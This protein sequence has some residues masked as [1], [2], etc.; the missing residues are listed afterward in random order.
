MSSERS[1]LF[2]KL[3]CLNYNENRTDPARD[4]VP[5]EKLDAVPDFHEEHIEEYITLDFIF[6]FWLLFCL[7]QIERQRRTVGIQ[8]SHGSEWQALRLDAFQQVHTPD[9]LLLDS[10]QPGIV[11]W[12]C[13]LE[14]SEVQGEYVFLR[15][16]TFFLTIAHRSRKEANARF[17][18]VQA[19]WRRVMKR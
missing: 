12:D 3:I 19:A 6:L 7:R 18:R 8:E 15:G 2:T 10:L 16:A 14:S 9:N 4:A 13:R 17:H 1:V 5:K 11:R